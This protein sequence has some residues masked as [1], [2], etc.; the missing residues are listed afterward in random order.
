MSSNSDWELPKFDMVEL[1][2][3][4]LLLL[5]W[6]ICSASGLLPN[7]TLDELMNNWNSTRLKVWESILN[8]KNIKKT[9][10]VTTIPFEVDEITAR[11]LLSV[12]PTTFRWGTGN[13]CGYSLKLKLYRFI[14]GDTDAEQQSSSPTEDKAGDNAKDQTP[15]LSV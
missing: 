8:I 4:E 12:T 14:N 2:E 6:V 7:V 10:Q 9:Q 1:T 3:E 11:V 15:D 13:D 5:D